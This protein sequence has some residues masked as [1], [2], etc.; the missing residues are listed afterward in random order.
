MKSNTGPI[1]LIV[2]GSLLTLGP[3][4]GLLGT[5]V[6]IARAFGRLEGPGAANP[7]NLAA[8]MSLWLWATAA[9]FVM[10]FIGLV[11]LVGGIVWIVRVSRREKTTVTNHG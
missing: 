9:G 8:D 7:E 6:G 10:E 11:L 4:V 1:S 2:V 3:L 5:I